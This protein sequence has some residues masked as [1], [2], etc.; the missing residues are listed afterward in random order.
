M[1]DYMGKPVRMEDLVKALE[2]L[3]ATGFN[4]AG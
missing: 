1:D 3:H 2:R 4:T